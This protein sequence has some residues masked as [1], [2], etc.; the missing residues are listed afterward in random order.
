VV[1]VFVGWARRG[2]EEGEESGEVE[3]HFVRVVGWLDEM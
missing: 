3:M 2:V 1:V